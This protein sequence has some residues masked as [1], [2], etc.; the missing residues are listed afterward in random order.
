M[1]DCTQEAMLSCMHVLS[2]TGCRS[3]SYW[4]TDLN[5]NTSQVPNITLYDQWLLRNW[6]K[7]KN[8]RESLDRKLYITLKSSRQTFWARF[9]MITSKMWPLEHQQDFPLIWPGEL[10]F[11]IKWPSFK[12]DLEIIKTNILS[13][14]YDDYFKIVTS[15]VLTVF[16]WLARSPSFWLHVTLFQTWPRNHQDKHFEQDS[17]WL[18]HKCDR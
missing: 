8:L 12:L 14:I 5:I 15:G 11:Y 13:N 7:W 6:P 17:R 2:T 1:D 16:C 3:N 18:L 4:E 9:M 10:V